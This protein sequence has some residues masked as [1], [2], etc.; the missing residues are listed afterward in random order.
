MIRECLYS[1][2]DLFKHTLYP[3]TA[4]TDEAAS[5]ELKSFRI[6]SW[7]QRGRKKVFLRDR[8]CSLCSVAEHRQVATGEWSVQ[9]L[10]FGDIQ[11][12]LR[13]IQERFWS[14]HVIS[15]AGGVEGDK[16]EAPRSQRAVVKIWQH[17]CGKQSMWKQGWWTDRLQLVELHSAPSPAHL[18][19]SDI[20]LSLFL[21]LSA[22]ITDSASSTK[23]T[24][25]RRSFLV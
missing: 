25:H 19:Q 9:C 1:M 22:D 20:C 23:T 3:Q 21:A 24:A 6:E 17:G 16:A 2:S 18:S 11:S 14:E 10:C 15:E 5:L 8:K 4:Q 13:G 7:I 12:G